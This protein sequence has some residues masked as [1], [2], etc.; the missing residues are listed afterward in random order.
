MALRGFN[1]NIDKKRNQL[2]QKEFPTGV[3]A[4]RKMKY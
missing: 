1:I 4:Q 3:N 2:K